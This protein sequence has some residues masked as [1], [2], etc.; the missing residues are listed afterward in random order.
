MN[1][2]DFNALM[3]SASYDPH[4][5][6]RVF[7]P[8]ACGQPD[9]SAAP[10]QLLWRV[11]DDFRDAIHFEAHAKDCN[12][13][14][15][16]ITADSGDWAGKPRRMSLFLRGAYE[17]AEAL[18]RIAKEAPDDGGLVAARVLVR[19][20]DNP[21][22]D[23]IEREFDAEMGPGAYRRMIDHV[24]AGGHAARIGE[25]ERRFKTPDAFWRFMSNPRERGL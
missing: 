13:R 7:T 2:E 19:R 17:L 8:C 3:A 12:S 21:Q 10:L 11:A 25:I 24:K 23:E 20:T 14:R 15:Y 16:T 22:A 5:R 4:E 6:R 9:L 1:R 18:C